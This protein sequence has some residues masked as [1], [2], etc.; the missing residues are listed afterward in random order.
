MDRELMVAAFIAGVCTGV[1]LTLL[2]L[3]VLIKRSEYDE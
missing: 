1:V 2:V 3:W